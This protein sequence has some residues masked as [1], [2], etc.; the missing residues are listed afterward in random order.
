MKLITR[1]DF[2]GLICAIYLK[3]IFPIDQ[4]EFVEPKF[5]Q[6]GQVIVTKNDIIANLPY[7]EN[8][9]Y[10]FDHHVS[11]EIPID[12]KGIFQVAPSAAGLIWEYYRADFPELEKYEYLTK[13]T[14]VIDGALLSKHETIHPIGYV[15]ISM[16]VTGTVETEHDYWMHLIDKLE[17]L[18]EDEALKDPVIKARTD[19]F[20][21]HEQDFKS[22]LNQHTIVNKNIIITDFRNA[23]EIK[24]SNRFLV[25]AIHPKG[26]V[27][28]TI[29]FDSQRP[30]YTAISVGKSIFNRTCDVN[31]GEMLKAFGG[32][33]HAGAGSTRVPNED[34]D[35]VLKQIYEQLVTND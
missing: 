32:G 11:N 3:K 10:W 12:F 5:M 13:R 34:T 33:G 9:A 25:Y 4:I 28:V 31:I 1:P 16:T 27:S 26:N 23:K 19:E 35:F 20:L 15:L 21:S 7:H 6:D 30:N 18:D 22:L 24:S 17:Y 14:D 2:D 29:K 8:C